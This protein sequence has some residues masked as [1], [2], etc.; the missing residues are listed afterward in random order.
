M[1][2]DY[3]PGTHILWNEY[4]CRHC[5]ALPPDFYKDDEISIEYASLFNA[6]E[7]IR[8]RYI[9]ESD[10]NV[11]PATSGYRCPDH[12]L[13]MYLTKQSGSPYSVHIFGLALDL[14]PKDKHDGVDSLVLIA[15]GLEFPVRIGWRSYYDRENPIVH[16]DIGWMILPRFSEKLRKEARW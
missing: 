15:E 5:G 3:I 8:E 11:L 6:Y 13:K 4:K 1:S 14:Q 16:I 2:R 7:L 9:M 12:Q 10:Y